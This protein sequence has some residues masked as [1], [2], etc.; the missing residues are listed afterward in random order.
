[1]YKVTKCFSAFYRNADSVF[2][3]EPKTFCYPKRFGFNISEALDRRFSIA[4]VR[5]ISSNGKGKKNKKGANKPGYILECL[6]SLKTRIPSRF[7]SIVKFSETVVLPTGRSSSAP[8]SPFLPLHDLILS[9]SLH[10]YP[11]SVS[12]LLAVNM[13]ER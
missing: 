3:A 5:Y 4:I 13:A 10:P 2:L 11:S 1:M 7:A 6:L 9:F 8:A 12:S